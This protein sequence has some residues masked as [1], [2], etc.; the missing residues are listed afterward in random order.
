ME[1]TRDN[2]PARVLIK[3]GFVGAG[4][5]PKQVAESIDICEFS[6]RQR[7]IQVFDEDQVEAR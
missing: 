3:G 5:L 1:S 6:F 4:T 7:A 2:S